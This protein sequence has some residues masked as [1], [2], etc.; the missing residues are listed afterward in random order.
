VIG[1]GV[2]ANMTASLGEA[3]DQPW[4]DLRAVI[5]RPV[6]RN[7]LAARLLGRLGAGLERF[8]REGFPPFRGGWDRLDL[9]RGRTV[10]VTVGEGTVAGTCRGIDDSGALLVQAGGRTDRY[11][12]GEVSVR[13]LA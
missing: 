5:G 8:A 11:L 6:D 2:N 1:V 10:T 13:L 9:A 7:L 12:S 4:V 3:I